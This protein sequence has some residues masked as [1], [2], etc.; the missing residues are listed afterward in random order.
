MQSIL[1]IPVIYICFGKIPNYLHLNI[2]LAAR[3]N[4][5]I[6]L[7]SQELN[8]LAT[9]YPHDS[10]KYN[11]HFDALQ[12]YSVGANA[13]APHYKHMVNEVLTLLINVLILL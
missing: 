3:Y 4:P 8:D 6:V 5:V 2:E 11:V 7:T 12:N 1:L 9:H 13:F 10:N